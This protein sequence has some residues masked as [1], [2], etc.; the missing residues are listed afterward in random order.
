[1][2]E[3]ALKLDNTQNDAVCKIVYDCNKFEFS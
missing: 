1:M 2:P 3:K